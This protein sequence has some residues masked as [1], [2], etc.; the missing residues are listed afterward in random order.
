MGR[1][2]K[3]KPEFCQELEDFF[4]VEPYEDVKLPHYNN[5]QVKW[6]DIKRLPNKLPTLVQ[7]AKSVKVGIRT[8]YDWIDEKHSS[9]QK[10]FSQTFTHVAKRTSKRLHYPERITRFI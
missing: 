1:P 7:F 5:G 3:Y 4:N 2:S 8:V 10:E 9:Y 6:E